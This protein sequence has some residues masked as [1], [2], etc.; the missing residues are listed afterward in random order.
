MTKLKLYSMS[1]VRKLK[2][3]KI[4]VAMICLLAFFLYYSAMILSVVQSTVDQISRGSASACVANDGRAVAHD[5]DPDFEAKL[6]NAINLMKEKYDEHE[7]PIIQT[8]GPSFHFLTTDPRKL[9]RGWPALSRAWNET[10]AVTDDEAVTRNSCDIW[11]SQGLE[12]ILI[13]QAMEENSDKPPVRV[14]TSGKYA[15]FSGWYVG[16]FG[17]FTHDHASKIAWLRSLVSDDTMF[18]LP[19]DE[20]HEAIMKVVDEDFVTNRVVWV[21]YDQTVY[22]NEGSLT[23]MIPRS[24]YPFPGGYPQTGTKYTEE[25]RKWL[26]E[27]HWQSSEPPLRKPDNQGKVIFYTRKGSTV[28]RI[29]EEQLEEL[30]IQKIRESMLKYGRKE[31]DLVIFSGKDEEGN[32]LPM[33]AQFDLFSS[34]DIAIG[35]HGS[36]LTNVIWMDPRCHKKNRPKVLEFASSQRSP[37]VQHGSYWGYWFLFG[38]LP[39]IDYHQLYY[40]ENSS[41]SRVF[42]D[43]ETFQITLDNMLG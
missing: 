32:T 19:Y 20:L 15:A 40:T 24:N 27:S 2:Y 34:A 38:S 41:D 18:L 39:W 30:L 21:Q 10:Y 6:T 3:H 4:L 36:G 28:R 11:G 23:V 9:G 37:K 8:I 31:D 1:F 7:M 5:K 12:D 42:I 22:V 29:V 16:N 13:Q 26:E 25:F 17:H 33:K 14:L 43:P 35:P